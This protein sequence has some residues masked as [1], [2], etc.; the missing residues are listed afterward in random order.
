MFTGATALVIK[1]LQQGA[2]NLHNIGFLNFGNGSS[3]AGDMDPNPNTA[4]DE[5][6]PGG[7]K[8]FSFNFSQEFGPPYLC[9]CAEANYSVINYERLQ[10]WGAEA[11]GSSPSGFIQK[12]PGWVTVDSFDARD[13]VK[14]TDRAIS[15]PQ[16]AI[17]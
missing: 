3:A 16:L 15:L 11:Q 12:T 7:P 2:T 6:D 9:G 17:P 13:E 1:N 14:G 5:T 8:E 10:G 4:F